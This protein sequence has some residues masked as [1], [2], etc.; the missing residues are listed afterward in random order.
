M[1][2]AKTTLSQRGEGTD[3][4]PQIKRPHPELWRAP[5]FDGPAS[6]QMMYGSTCVWGVRWLGERRAVGCGAG[7]TGQSRACVSSDSLCV[8]DAVNCLPWGLAAMS[9]SYNGYSGG[10]NCGGS[11]ACALFGYPYRPICTRTGRRGS[12]CRSLRKR[13]G[14]VRRLS[15]PR[16]GP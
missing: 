10:N 16:L 5:E 9:A 13:E 4:S 8:W 1:N 7:Q 2:L 3:V 6:L 15:I 11:G 12:V 14:L